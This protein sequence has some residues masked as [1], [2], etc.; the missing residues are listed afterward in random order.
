M[1]RT[2]P[3]TSDRPPPPPPGDAK[4]A[5]TYISAMTAELATLARRYDFDA[6][7]YIIDMA[8]LEAEGLV[9][10]LTGS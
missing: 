1:A 5:A 9:Q 3:G 10:R 8:R 6:L 7:A 4:A 2:R